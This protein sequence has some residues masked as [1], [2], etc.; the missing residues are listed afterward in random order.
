MT[1]KYYDKDGI[2]RDIAKLRDH[3]GMITR[4][5][6]LEYD[7]FY[8]A[9]TTHNTTNI[10]VEEARVSPY[11]TGHREMLLSSFVVLLG[12]YSWIQVLF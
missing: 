3:R 6:Q 10:F 4:S 11:Y 1:K 7:R 8:K 12:I 9:P 5:C 2:F